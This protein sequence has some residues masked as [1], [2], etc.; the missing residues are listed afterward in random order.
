[1][2]DKQKAMIDTYFKHWSV[3]RKGDRN[4]LERMSNQFRFD[5][6][7]DMIVVEYNG[8]YTAKKL[9]KHLPIGN[10]EDY[11]IIGIT[12]LDYTAWDGTL[13]QPQV[14]TIDRWGDL[15]Y[16]NLFWSCY[17]KKEF[18]AIR[19]RTDIKTLLIAQRK[20]NLRKIKPY[21]L[22]ADERYIRNTSYNC[23]KSGYSAW[24]WEYRLI[25]RLNEK[26]AKARKEEFLQADFSDKVATLN[27]LRDKK[28][29]EL[30]EMLTNAK[31]HEDYQKTER[32]FN[33]YHNYLWQFARISE[34]ENRIKE[35]DFNSVEEV[36]N[37]FDS[38]H[39]EFVGESEV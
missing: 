16:H 25:D 7:N 34:F 30:V 18:N 9:L 4:Y 17:S 10:I 2:T 36:V 32:A 6:N 24:E 38:I 14:F 5:Y 19:K 22:R 3:Y 13:R 21:E 12:C 31:T 26:K 28:K 35:D 33:R 39:R 20:E 29:A 37:L 15:D 23:D 8:N 27:E 1:M 11:K